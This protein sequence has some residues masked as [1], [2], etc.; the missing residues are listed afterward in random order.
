[1]PSWVALNAARER[2]LG[3]AV[4]DVADDE[5]VHRPGQ[6]HV[7]LDLRGRAQL[8]DGLLVREGRL[9]LGLPGRV[10]HERVALRVGT[11]GVQ[12]EEFLGEVVDGLADPLL[13]PEPL[14]PAQL[15]QGRPLPARVA[16]DAP[17]LLDRDEDAIATREGQL[18]VVTVLAGTA[19]SQHLLVAGD[20]VVDVDDQV[21]WREPVEDVAGDDPSE[22]PG[23]AD[24]DGPEQFAVRDEGEAVR[25]ADEP[26][27]EAPLDED[28]RA[29]RRHL[30]HPADDR[31]RVA[32]FAEHV[33]EPRRL[34]RREDD[35]GPIRAPRVDRLRDAPRPARWQ[36]GF[37]PA[38]WVA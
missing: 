29:R 5:P 34:V 1:M 16:R 33:G 23:P 7:G 28:H 8:V 31:D 25:A 30:A 15:G 35:P 11:R 12:R 3:L 9:H 19:P 18:E 24:P 27:V 22:R 37:A 14:R 38:E 4:A 17:D 6:L 21:A 26:A 2:D 36:D 10:G 13:R 32:G 20:A